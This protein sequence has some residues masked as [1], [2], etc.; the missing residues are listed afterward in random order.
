MGTA[1]KGSFSADPTSGRK[2]IGRPPGQLNKTTLTLRDAIMRCFTDLQKDP[3]N[4]L[5]EW[6]GREPTEFYRLASK[7]IPTEIVATVK[8][9]ITV[10]LLED[11]EDPGDESKDYVEFEDIDEDVE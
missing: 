9:T 7:L 5:L 10:R 1:N 11:E 4:N 3:V 6:A 2:P 8:E